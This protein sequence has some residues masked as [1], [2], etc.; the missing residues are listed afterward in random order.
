MI[1]GITK[2]LDFVHR[3]VSKHDVCSLVFLGI[4]D[5]AHGPKTH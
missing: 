1:V 3:A 5:D 2:L 4:L